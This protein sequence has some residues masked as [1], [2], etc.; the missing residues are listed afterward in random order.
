MRNQP[1]ADV[2]LVLEGTYPYVSGGVSMWTHHL[3]QAQSHLS[4]ELVCLVPERAELT[5]RYQVPP[6]V[7]GITN[8]PVGALS[9]GDRR[10]ARTT[11]GATRALFERLERPLLQL[12]AGGGL[13]EVAAILHELSPFRPRL[14]RRVLLNSPEA[15]EL[16]L[17]MYRGTHPE[18]AF[19]DYFWSWRAILGGIFSMLLAPLPS[20][21]LYH[22]VSTGYAGLYAARAHLQTGR[23]ALLTEHGIYTNERHIEI[24]MAD[25]L[26]HPAESG[27]T[28]EKSPRDLRIMWFRAFAAYS[29]ACYQAASRIITLH[30]AN[31]SFQIAD[32]APPEKLTI[33]PNGIDYSR[34]SA[35]VKEREEHPL[36]IA[37]IG[38][39]VPIK[40]VK[41]FIR[42]VAIVRELV[43]EV[44]ALVLGPADEDPQ[45]LAECQALVSHLGLESSVEFTGPVSVAEYLPRLD[46]AVLTSISEAQPLVI[47][48]AGAAGVPCVATDVGACREMIYGGPHEDPALGAG[49]EVTPLANPTATAHAVSRLLLDRDYWERASRAMRER[50]RLYYDKRALDRS[51]RDLYEHWC[52]V[53]DQAPAEVLPI[54]RKDVA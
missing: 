10:L 51:Y 36:A 35:L 45:Y 37:L 6:N 8:I 54:P 41:T 49:G 23:P 2:C 21:R 4:F 47:L 44:R 42:A 7:I 46:V 48:E 38:R 15:W 29:R 43:S 22:A 5:R 13:A 53:P 30:S 3:I 18:S 34:Y 24:A 17:R 31:Q 26:Y 12:Q 27:L 20:A 33:I 16:I 28:L 52:A 11:P 25:W 32:G 39:V 9:A 40:D 19:L 1:Q 14:G 50:V